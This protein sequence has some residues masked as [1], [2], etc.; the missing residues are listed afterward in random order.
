MRRLKGKKLFFP[1]ELPNIIA[2]EARRLWAGR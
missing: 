1:E 2:D